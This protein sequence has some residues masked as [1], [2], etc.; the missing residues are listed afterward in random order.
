MRRNIIF[1]I[2][3]EAE[4][5]PPFRHSPFSTN[6]K[7]AEADFLFVENGSLSGIEPESKVPQ[8]SVLTVTP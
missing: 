3:W 1:R 4:K 6:K 5:A 7:P 2:Y 8:T